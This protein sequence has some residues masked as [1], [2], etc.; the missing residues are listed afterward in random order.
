[1]SK[2]RASRFLLNVNCSVSIW[3]YSLCFVDDRVCMCGNAHMRGQLHQ[4]TIDATVPFEA[5]L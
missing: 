4:L 2:L 5:D 1:M 3:N